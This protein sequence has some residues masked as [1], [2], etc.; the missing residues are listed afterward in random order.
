MG[1]CGQGPTA[2]AP[3][4]RRGGNIS[5]DGLDRYGWTLAV[6][7]ADGRDVAAGAKEWCRLQESNPRPPDYKSKYVG[8]RRGKHQEIYKLKWRISGIYLGSMGKQANTTGNPKVSPMLA[9]KPERGPAMTAPKSLLKGFARTVA[10]AKPDPSKRVH[11]FDPDTRGLCLRIT[12]K[13]KKTFTI[14]A[15]DPSGKQVWREVGDAGQMT[16]EEVREKAREGVERLKRG[17]DP[18]PVLELPAP[19]ESFETVM[20]TFLQ[21][22]VKKRGLRTAGEIERALNTNVLPEWKNRE[23]RSIRR[24][25]VAK[26]L[27]EIEDDRGPV[28]ADRTLAYLSKLFNWY[29]ARDD[30]FSSPIVRGMARTKPRERARKRILDDNEIRLIWPLLEGSYGAMVKVSLLTAQRRAKVAAMRWDELAEDGTWTIPS[31]DREKS[32]AEVLK[33]PDDTLDIIRSIKRVKGNPYIFAGRGDVHL[34]GFSEL[35][36][37]LD[38][39]ILEALKKQAKGE[40]P[41]KVKPLERWTLHDL[42][43][44]AKSLMARAGVRPD[45]SERVLG[46]VIPGVEGVYDRYAYAEEK[47]EALEKLAKLV[48]R[49]LDPPAENVVELRGKKVQQW[50]VPQG[51]V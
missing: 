34:A 1:L 40:N 22:H 7:L 4:R 25:D 27:D 21:R 3:E 23:F 30:E 9:Q 2:G 46:H 41:K 6:V 45:I 17:E 44:T 35:K 38:A 32:N 36:A 49:I 12:P 47:T 48:G 29:V 20:K 28:M 13:G 19:P 8:G 5:P 15:R 50:V 37:S 33:L 43:R 18:F 24:S 10:N 31:D 51:V 11:L 26:L 16:L 39:R 42:R 14:V